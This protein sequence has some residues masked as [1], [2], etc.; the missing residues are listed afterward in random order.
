MMSELSREIVLEILKS[1]RKELME[2]GAERLALFGSV[3]RGETMVGSDIDILVEFNDNARSDSW[4]YFSVRQVLLDR[5]KTVLGVS[6]DLSDAALQRPEIREHSRQD[7]I[8][9]F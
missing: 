2:L 4:H 9:V 6:V 3:A 1:H 7:R 5:L 8:Y